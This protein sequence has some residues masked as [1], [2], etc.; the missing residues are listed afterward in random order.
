MLPWGTPTGNICWVD[1]QFSTDVTWCRLSRYEENH[2]TT[3]EL[4]PMVIALTA[5][6]CG[7]EPIRYV[8]LHSRDRRGATSLFYRNRAE[9]TVL[10]AEKQKPCPVNLI[11]RLFPLKNER[12]PFPFSKGKGLIG[13]FR[14]L[15]TLT[16][17]MRASARPFLWKLVLLAWEWK[18]ISISK[19]EPPLNLV[20]I[21]RGTRKWSIYVL[22]RVAN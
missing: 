16:F 1:W 8:R 20:L 3:W 6:K 4:A 12:P 10:I 15:K 2:F 5:P 17:K 9:I 13:H 19:A 21:Q 18:I 14:V 11:P 7:T 22:L